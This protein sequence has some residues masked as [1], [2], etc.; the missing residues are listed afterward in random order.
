[1]L[2]LARLPP[3]HSSPAAAATCCHGPLLIAVCCL[4]APVFAAFVVC[5]LL[6]A[7]DFWT[8]KNITGR[9]LVGL[10][11]WNEVKEDGTNVWIF[12]S[13]PDQRQV[14]PTDN[15]VFWGALYA[16]PVVW[17][18]LA[19]SVLLRPQWLLV[20]AVA[21]TFSGANVVGYWKCSRDAGRRVQQFI[22]T[23][24]L[25]AAVPAAAATI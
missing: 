20:V 8:V 4:A 18:L 24:V 16:T 7:F 10:R 22:T 1:L 17:I 6:L 14:H 12:E 9:L 13:K 5:V 15:M 3:V 2:L 11:W 25:A 19:L 21:V 23:R